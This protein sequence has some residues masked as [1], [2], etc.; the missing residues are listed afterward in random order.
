MP[1]RLSA[2]ARK[3]V[4]TSATQEARRLGDRRL[5]TDHLLLGLLHDEDFPAAKAL[6]V[7]LA[8]A[9]TASEAL[10][11]AALVAVGIEIQALGEGAAGL[12][13]PPA[14]AAHFWC[15]GGLQACHRRGASVQERADRHHALPARLAVAAAP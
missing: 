13:R 4:L 1:K 12:V 9:R 14:P 3:L 7:S 15:A 2:D 10:D 5:G 11:R 8:D 6:G